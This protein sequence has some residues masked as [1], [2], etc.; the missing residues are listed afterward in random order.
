MTAPLDPRR[1]KYAG[2]ITHHLP[3]GSPEQVDEAT[4]A[5]MRVADRERQEMAA[6]RFTWQE[7][8]DKAE[9]RL[10]RAHQAR[11]AKE[12]QLDGI[13]RALCDIGF[14]QDDDPYG[15]ADLEDV[16]RQNAPDPAAIE[17]ADTSS[18]LFGGS[19]DLSIP[20][21][22]VNEGD[23]PDGEQAAEWA[24]PPP[25]DRREQLPDHLHDLIR[26]E[27]PNY[28]STACG[29]AQVLS[30]A[31]CY[32]GSGIPRLQYD[33]IRGHAEHLHERCRINHKFTGQLCV[34]GCHPEQHE[35]HP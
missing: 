20:D 23:M 28:L 25:G 21:H 29:T 32:P 1:E 4:T 31:A 9:T 14:M 6:E 11:R 7:R 24:P 10:R 18:W 2:A 12:H 8:G 33:E 17:A 16:I 3:W 13:R 26:D 15:H 19:R 30:L 22:Q 34:C 5:V 35:D 27:M